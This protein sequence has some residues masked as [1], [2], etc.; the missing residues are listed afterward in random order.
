MPPSRQL[1]RRRHRTRCHLQQQEPRVPGPHLPRA[2]TSPFAGHERYIGTACPLGPLSRGFRG[3]SSVASLPP[4]F[5]DPACPTSLCPTANGNAGLSGKGR[6]R[7]SRSSYRANAC[8]GQAGA[9]V[10]TAQQPMIHGRKGCEI[11]ERCGFGFETDSQSPEGARNGI[12]RTV[13]HVKRCSRMYLCY[14]TK[15]ITPDVVAG[16]VPRT[17]PK[18]T[19]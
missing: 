19:Q 4:V 6:W 14:M 7:E 16:N 15:A 2:P 5:H 18:E 8:L 12:I 11:G 9:S 1:T 3:I 17:K 13:Y 10:P